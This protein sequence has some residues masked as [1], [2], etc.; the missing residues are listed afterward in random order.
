MEKR[1]LRNNVFFSIIHHL[2][3][4]TVGLIVPRLILKQYGSGINGYTYSITQLLSVITYFD[5]GVSSVAQAALYRPL[6]EKNWSLIS[7]IYQAVKKY[8]RVLGIGLFFYVIF[9]C[10]Y[11]SF[12]RTDYSVFFSVSLVLCLAVSMIGQYLFGLTDQVLLSADQ[13]MYICTMVDIVAIS[14]NGLATYFGIKQGFSIQV[15]KLVT[16]VIFLIKPLLLH[17]YVLKRYQLLN[18]VSN[19]RYDIPQQW[20][21]L[22]QHI[23]SM[24]IIS[25]DTIVLTIC[26]SFHNIS[27]YN[28]Y[29]FPLNGL[30]GLVTS[31]GGGYKSFL[32][33]ALVSESEETLSKEFAK[34]E[35]LFHFFA[36]LVFC[37]SVTMIVP[38]V[39][40][41]T[42]GV[43]DAEYINYPF[44]YL[45]VAS[46]ALLILRIPYTTV[47]NS[48]GH[49]KETQLYCVVEMIVNILV[50][51]ALTTQY[52]L[53][54]VTIGTLLA[55][56]Y[57]L[58]A[59]VIYLRRNILTRKIKYFIKRVFEDLVIIVIYGM[60]SHRMIVKADSY[61]AWSGYAVLA[62]FIFLMISMVVYSISDLKVVVAMVEQVRK[63]HK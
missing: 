13:K 46:Y 11:Y 21:G 54:G 53:V 58:I 31:V 25:L 4:V 20:S 9:L 50:S 45:I 40:I 27:V 22:V 57:R 5:F 12:S 60:I 61:L 49:F 19:D 42:T 34:F 28:V 26:S 29:T 62:T 23:A 41:Y 36:N 35:M 15:V 38:F 6:V 37:V 48:A 39:K 14:V 55:I 30:R 10:G 18:C 8:F 3:S 52:G 56:G 7:V 63:S 24:L 51:F 47:I 44:S 33:Q 2:V 59:S 17:W 32:G 1:N 16:S 43:D